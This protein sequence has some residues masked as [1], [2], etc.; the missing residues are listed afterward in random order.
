MH[1]GARGDYL[2][3]ARSRP[4]GTRGRVGEA[5]ARPTKGPQR[6]RRKKRRRKRERERER[7]RERKER[8]TKKASHEGKVAAANVAD[9]RLGGGV[10]NVHSHGG[11]GVSQGAL[12]VCARVYVCVRE[13]KRRNEA[14]ER[15]EA[16]SASEFF[17]QSIYVERERERPEF[18][19]GEGEAQ[20]RAAADARKRRQRQR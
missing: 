3:R 15:V 8:E 5:A 16:R 18:Q 10:C 12:C 17:F 1:D 6:R 19:R 2:S 11:G 14:K 7:E 13:S 20:S 4:E 9:V